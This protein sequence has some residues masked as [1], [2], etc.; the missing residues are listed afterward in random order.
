MEI[1]EG[2]TQRANPNQNPDGETFNL[3]IASGDSPPSPTENNGGVA[4]F[5]RYLEN[6]RQ[7]GGSCRETDGIPA[8]I[9]GSLIQFKRSAYDTAPFWHGSQNAPNEIVPSRFGYQID[10]DDRGNG[11]F[12]PYAAASGRL[13][14]YMAPKRRYGFDVALLT[15]LPDLFSGLFTTPSAG[16]PDEFFREVS[17]DDSWVETLLCAKDDKGNLAVNGRYCRK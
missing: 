4:N 11:S 16:D 14:Y 12:M 8:R 5:V 9:S 1:Q 15:Q 6:W 13:P 2:W 10:D 3:V 7:P 17:R